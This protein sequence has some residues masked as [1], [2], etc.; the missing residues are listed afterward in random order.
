MSV[1][2]YFILQKG[3]GD[4]VYADLGP[5]SRKK[6]NFIPNSIPEDRVV[7][8][9]INTKATAQLQGNTIIIITLQY[10]SNPVQLQVHHLMLPLT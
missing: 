7:Y 1:I 4:L 3:S 5:Q 9:A 2:C 6:T 8:S 10:S